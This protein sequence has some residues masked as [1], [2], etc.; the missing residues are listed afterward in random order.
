MILLLLPL[1][2]AAVLAGW[3]PGR[4]PQQIAA[5]RTALVTVSDARNRLIVDLGPD[6]FVITEG[7]QPREILDARVADYPVV[8]L[9]DTGRAART[10][11]S[12]IR[13]AVARFVDRLGERPIAIGTLGDPPA[14]VATFDDSRS[15]R[16]KRLEALN[17]DPGAETLT[18]EAAA[19]AARI[20]GGAGS[21][22]SA[23]VIVSASLS[24]GSRRS[25][26]ELVP[27]II[28]C[29]ASVHAIVNRVSAEAPIAGLTEVLRRLSDQTHGQFS[30]IYS[31]ASYRVALDRLADRL[32]S[33]MMIEYLVPPGSPAT[34]IQI[35]VR[36][37][38]TRAHGLGVRPR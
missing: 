22:F 30:T 31:A 7:G 32:A 37:P 34:D 28:D 20:L 15:V 27:P 33:E 23:I 29:G 19:G 3:T 25:S 14:T 2:A 10:S 21:R 26:D 11:F 18:L 6:D 36:I 17:A 24:D 8:V 4:A 13:Q 16:T 38:G 1:I 5:S 9:V 35:G 12:D